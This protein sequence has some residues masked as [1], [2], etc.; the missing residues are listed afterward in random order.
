MDE[1]YTPNPVVPREMVN[2]I[3]LNLGSYVGLHTHTHGCG[4]TFLKGETFALNSTCLSFNFVTE[5]GRWIANCNSA[6]F[7]LGYK[8]KVEHL[9]SKGRPVY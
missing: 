2:E 3:K 8:F 1:S 7:T 4:N 9:P 6:T 5:D